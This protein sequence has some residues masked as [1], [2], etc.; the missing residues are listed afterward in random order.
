MMSKVTFFNDGKSKRKQTNL[1]SWFVEANDLP[2]MKMVFS[3]V[4]F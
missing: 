2:A 1:K 4:K 3:K